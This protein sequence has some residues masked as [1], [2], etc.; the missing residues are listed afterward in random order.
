MTTIN[1]ADTPTLGALLRDLRHAAGLSAPGVADLIG[2]TKAT[3][4]HWE[5]DHGQPPGKDAT[6]RL[7]ALFAVDPDLLHVL[8]GRV[9]PDLAEAL[10]DYAT[11]KRVRR[12]LADP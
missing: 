12:C 3:V 10:T 1:L 4:Y 9:P 11:V 8:A 6:A 5:Q 2:V 7:A